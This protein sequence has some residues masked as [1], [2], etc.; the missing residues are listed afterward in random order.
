ME[1]AERTAVEQK[2]KKSYQA[3]SFEGKTPLD[4]VKGTYYY[5]TYTYYYYYYYW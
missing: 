2:E 4:H 3:P 5:T 1:K